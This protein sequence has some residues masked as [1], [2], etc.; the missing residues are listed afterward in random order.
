M[1]SSLNSPRRQSCDDQVLV[2]CNIAVNDDSDDF[3]S[4]GREE[5]LKKISFPGIS[6]QSL[7]STYENCQLATS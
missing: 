5:V 7:T 3:I 6:L 4:W 2:A 1:I